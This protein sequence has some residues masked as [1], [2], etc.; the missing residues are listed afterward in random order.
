[1]A[2]KECFGRALFSLIQDFAIY[3]EKMHIDV[4][5]SIMYYY[6]IKSGLWTDI[7]IDQYKFTGEQGIAL[8][9]CLQ[10]TTN[11]NN[12]SIFSVT[13]VSVIF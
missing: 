11:N 10:K 13:E 9:L 5:L 1:M 7:K 6:T 2:L 12:I 4:L 3:E 8:G